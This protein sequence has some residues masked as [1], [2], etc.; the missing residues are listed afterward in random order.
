ML[1]LSRRV[2]ES[3]MVGDD[4]EIIVASIG[5]NKVRLGI[6]APIETPVHRKEIY[7][8]LKKAGRELQHS[9]RKRS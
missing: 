6:T 8:T 7:K 5:R 2:N 9:Y 3:V 4:V 1:V